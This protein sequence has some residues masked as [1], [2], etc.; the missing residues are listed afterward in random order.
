MNAFEIYLL[1]KLALLGAIAPI[2]AFLSGLWWV[3][4][5]VTLNEEPEEDRAKLV[6]ESIYPKNIFKILGSLVIIFIIMGIT[7]PSKKDMLIMYGIPYIT[8]QKDFRKL[9]ANTAKTVNKLL[10]D[11]TKKGE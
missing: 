8:H 7:I 6:E 4:L 5:I 9:P 10:T 3:I 1:L 11:Y 2:L